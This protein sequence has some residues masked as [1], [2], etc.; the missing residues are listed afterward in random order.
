MST[1]SEQIQ[2][3]DD[4]VV[5]VEEPIKTVALDPQ[6]FEIDLNVGSEE[7]PKLVS[8][9]LRAPLPEEDFD[10]AKKISTE[11]RDAG[12]SEDEIVVDDEVASV[13]LFD[14][15]VTHTRGFALRGESKEKAEEF[16]DASE[17]KHLIPKAWKSAFVRGM[18]IASAKHVEDDNDF[19]VLGGDDVIEVDFTVGYDENPVGSAKVFVP[20]PQESERVSFADNSLKFL[21]GRGKK[22]NSRLVTNLK[23]CAEFFDTLMNRTGAD[24]VGGTVGG[25]TFAQCESPLSKKIFLAGINPVYKAKIIN[26]AMAR[27]NARLQD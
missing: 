26:A 14:L 19:V 27:Y 16:R 23:V 8:A 21:Q 2:L 5:L 10:F 9:K 18:R 20:E 24:I 6:S 3:F 25:K 4:A 17:V 7:K 11:Y 12:N 13:T 15:C 22:K 1:V